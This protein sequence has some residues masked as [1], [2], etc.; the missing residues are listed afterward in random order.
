MIEQMSWLGL[1]VKDIE[2]ATAFYRDK[3]GLGV[4]GALADLEL[5]GEVLGAQQAPALEQEQV[6]QQ[7]IN[8]VHR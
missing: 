5:A 7:A 1:V 4:D 6:A 8:A 2:A 3:L